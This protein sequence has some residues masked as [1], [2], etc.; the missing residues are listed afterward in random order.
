[1]LLLLVEEENIDHG[2][3]LRFNGGALS[4]IAE[5]S[6]I[7]TNPRRCLFMSRVMSINQLLIDIIIGTR[8]SF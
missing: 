5:L 7:T 1:L 3:Q 6:E 8:N 4:D 2:W